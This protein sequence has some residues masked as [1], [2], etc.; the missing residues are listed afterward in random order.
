MRVADD[1][2]PVTRRVRTDTAR[3]IL[4]ISADPR[5]WE[6]GRQVD[7]TGTR[8]RLQALV[9]I[10]YSLRALA[11]HLGVRTTDVGRLLIQQRV[12][13]RT[14]WAVDDLYH[15]LWD[16]IPPVTT[17][18]ERRAVREARALAQERR[19]LPPLA[20]DDIDN[21]PAPAPLAR[22]TADDLDD[23]AVERAIVGDGVRFDHLTTAEQCEAVRRLTQL[24]L[25]VRDIGDVLGTTSRTVSRRRLMLRAA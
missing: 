3:R 5:F 18:A 22:V 10:G 13:A 6:P 24:G 2:T 11:K 17:D 8:R 25:S 4:A 21:D 15:E 16:V 20:W 14:A 23:I 1:G 9:A 7:S 12:L 19:W